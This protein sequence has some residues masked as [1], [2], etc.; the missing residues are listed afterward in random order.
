MTTA[1]CG[2]NVFAVHARLRI[3]TRKLTMR[4]MAIR[5]HGGDD[6]PAL[7][8]SLAVNALC[9]AFDDLVF[10][11]CVPYSSFLSLAMTSS[12]KIGN[13]CGEGCRPRIT[14]SKCAVLAMTL[15]TAG[16]VCIILRKQLTVGALLILLS[17]FCVAGGAIHFLRDCFTGSQARRRD[18]R[19]A[20]TARRLRVTRLRKFQRVDIEGS[21]VALRLDVRL[22]VTPETVSISHPLIVVHFSNLVRL[23]AINARWE[24]VCL[25]FPE[26]S[27]NDLSVYLFNLCVAL[28]A[29]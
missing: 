19:V 13:I 6:K 8:K 29:C 5:T 10:L 14:L 18:P 7:E 26:F 20:L 22:L 2:S 23:M 11:P 24:H 25:F 28:S 27:L 16:S 9:I 3:L 12:A 17:N 21:P 4:R 1:T 15:Q